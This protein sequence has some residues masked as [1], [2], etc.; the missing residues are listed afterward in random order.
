MNAPAK[1]EALLFYRGHEVKFSSI[2][3]VLGWSDVELNDA[4]QALEANLCERGVRLVTSSTGALLAT[5]PEAASLVESLRK[6]DLDKELGRAASETLAIVL[7]RGPVT[8]EEIDYIRGVNSS[9][10][11]RTLM[12]RGLVEQVKSADS[13]KKIL[14]A[15]TTE[16]L[17]H[18]GVGNQRNMPDFDKAHF[19]LEEAVMAGKA[20]DDIRTASSEEQHG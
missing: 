14:Y 6:D 20:T 18:L 16:L 5:A 11:L 12:V 13:T 19:D 9:I 2:R 7:Y 17:A 4:L 8:R 10:M 3:K 1:L 15:P